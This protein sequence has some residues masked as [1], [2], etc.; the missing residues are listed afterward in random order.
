M[1]LLDAGTVR[2]LVH[3]DAWAP[4]LRELPS[5]ARVTGRGG[6]IP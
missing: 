1:H 4:D 6:W 2:K 5:P 3:E